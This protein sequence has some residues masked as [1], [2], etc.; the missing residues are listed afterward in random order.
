[1]AISVGA[2]WGAAAGTFRRRWPFVVAFTLLLFTTLQI[3]KRFST[4]RLDRLDIWALFELAGAVV[5]LGLVVG[6][7]SFAAGVFDHLVADDQH[8]V[9]APF[10]REI[11]RRLPYRSLIAVAILYA[12][13]VAFAT[14]VLVIPGLV[15]LTFW[16]VSSS[17][18]VIEGRTAP[19]ALARSFR[20]TRRHFRTTFG[21]VTVLLIVEYAIERA[22]HEATWLRANHWAGVAIEGVIAAS[23]GAFVAITEVTLAHRLARRYPEAPTDGAVG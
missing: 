9:P 19:S 1:L 16:A 14:A 8:G 11:A 12:L 20:L 3:A 15:L 7:T 23:F 18:V 10:L 21:A 22:L 2:V 6:A 17:M 4:V 13:G 5:S